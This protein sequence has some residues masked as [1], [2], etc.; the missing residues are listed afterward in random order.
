MSRITTDLFDITEFAHH[1]P[2][3]FFI[4]GI[5]IIGA[6]PFSAPR[7]SPKTYNFILSQAHGLYKTG[8]Y[9]KCSL[10][11][12]FSPFGSCTISSRVMALVNT[13]ATR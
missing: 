13:A 10:S 8:S 12:S 2:E 1:C 5:K 4:A 9:F 3:E 11:A 7:N 6:K